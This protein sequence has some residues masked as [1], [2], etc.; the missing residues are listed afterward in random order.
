MSKKGAMDS[1]TKIIIIIIAVIAI[2][3]ISQS[4]DITLFKTEGIQKEA[5][6]PTQPAQICVDPSVEYTL[7]YTSVAEGTGST[8]GIYHSFYV[9]GVW[10]T[11]VE[12]STFTASGATGKE[13]IVDVLYAT[14]LTTKKSS[15]S[16]YGALIKGIKTPC[17]P[18]KTSDP[19]ID[20]E[21]VSSLWRNGTVTIDIINPATGNINSA[22]QNMSLTASNIESAKVNFKVELYKAYAPNTNIVVSLQGNNTQYDKLYITGNGWSKASCP[23]EQ[24]DP[25]VVNVNQKWCYQHKGIKNGEEITGDLNIDT[26]DIDP[27]ADLGAAN[28]ITLTLFDT[29]YYINTQTHEYAVGVENDYFTEVG[30]AKIQKTIYIQ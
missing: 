1:S 30:F 19:A 26:S 4:G 14:N 8:N 27:T 28:A 3:Y 16:F 18:I 20:T 24:N 5:T 13:D 29:D 15:N 12:G 25:L 2:V 17:N 21:G 23:S 9:N 11:K 22:T 6:T 7:G 10:A